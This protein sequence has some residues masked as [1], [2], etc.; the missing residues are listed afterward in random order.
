MPKPRWAIEDV[1]VL[2]IGMTP[3]GKNQEGLKELA[4]TAAREAIADASISVAEIDAIYVSNFLG[5]IINGQQI[6]GSIVANELGLSGIPTMAVEGACASGG[7]AFRQAY[8]NTACGMYDKVLVIGVEKMTARSTKEI[9]LAI[10]SAM[11]QESWECKA[12]LTFPGYFGLVAN[13]YLSQYGGTSEDLASVVLK[14]REFA[15]ANHKAQFREPVDIE[16]YLQAKK[17][18][19]PLG[20][21][22]CSPITDGACAVVLSKS[23]QSTR[24]TSHSKVRVIASSQA[25]GPTQLKNIE[26]LTTLSAIIKAAEIAYTQSD[27]TPAH[28]DVVELHDCFSIT[29]ILSIEDLG[30]FE[31]G[32]GLKAVREGKTK[33]NGIIPVN[34]S[35]GLLSKGHPIGAT[36]LAQIYQIVSQLRG[37]AVNQVDGAR[38]GLAE[39]LGGTGAYATVHIF[40]GVQ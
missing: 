12:G 38:I 18:S 15:M 6:L 7:I 10:N 34:T 35:G 4:I 39:N 25:S 40:E 16:K 24:S 13:R 14:N 19:S 29:E 31:K 37:T 17:I 1:D 27:L 2:G 28:I 21:F 8:V 33:L 23:E 11:D 30:F 36:G 9:T 5:G 20:L 26:D 22:D 32:E 3:F